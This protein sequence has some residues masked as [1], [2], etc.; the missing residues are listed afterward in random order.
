MDSGRVIDSL[1]NNPL[2]GRPTILPDFFVD[3][4][5]I[6]GHLGEFI[7][8]LK[9]LAE[10][11]GGNLT[12]YGHL[13]R[14]GGNSVNTASALLSLGLNPCLIVK[15]DKQGASLL[16][17]LVSPQ[18]DLSHVHTDGRLSATVSIEVEE[19]GRRVNLMVSD[20]GSASDFS[21][22]DLTE[23]DIKAILESP[24]VALLCLN[25]NKNAPRLAED[26]FSM[27]R[28]KSKVL[29]FMDMGDPS[30]NPGIVEPLAKKVVSQGLVDI[31]GMNENEA[32]WFAGAIDG[33]TDKWHDTPAHPEKWVSAA[34]LVSHETGVRIDFHTPYFAASIKDDRITALPTFEVP[35]KITCGAGD[36]WNAGDILGTLLD[37]EAR[38]RIILAN[39][40]AAIYVSSDSAAHPTREALI[41]FLKGRQALS[42]VGSKLIRPL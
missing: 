41:E 18:L 19:R 3:H 8:G 5:V 32:S 27:V 21:Y 6:A 16:R 34:K 2:L 39:S 28:S 33:N 26:L 24:L 11:G 42:N 1:R 12:G 4:F 7:Q 10:Q 14:R 22:G 23:Y 29:T 9:R 31:L 13:I 36:A 15:T 40:V 35:V 17:S 38:D 20:S 37:L 25:H 30:N